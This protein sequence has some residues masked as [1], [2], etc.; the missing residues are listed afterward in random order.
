MLT[1]L[2]EGAVFALAAVDGEVDGAPLFGGEAEE[3]AGFG[4]H[5]GEEGVDGVVVGGVAASDVFFGELA[6]DGPDVEVGQGEGFAGSVDADVAGGGGGGFDADGGSGV[7]DELFAPD[8]GEGAGEPEDAAGRVALGVGVVVDFALPEP[9]D[10]DGVG[11]SVGAEGGED[12][13]FGLLEEVAE[14]GSKQSGHWGLLSGRGCCG[15]G[16][17]GYK[18]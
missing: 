15:R 2:L 14:V 8:A 18:G 12:A 4:L 16:G 3:H 11:S 5:V 10:G 17:C 7:A 9:P 6:G 1:I 13:V